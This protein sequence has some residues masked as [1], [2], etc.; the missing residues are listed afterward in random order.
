MTKKKIANLG[1]KR[2]R[3]RTFD[4]TVYELIESTITPSNRI[5]V[6]TPLSNFRY[7][8]TMLVRER[9]VQQAGGDAV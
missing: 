8:S 1:P 3:G 2:A 6:L 9:A 5:H 4:F 7:L